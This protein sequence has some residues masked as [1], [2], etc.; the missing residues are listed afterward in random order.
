MPRRKEYPGGDG[1]DDDYRRPHR[2]QRPMREGDI[3][4]K[5]GDPLAEEDTLI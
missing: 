5:V 4:T 2:D 3:Q 1:D